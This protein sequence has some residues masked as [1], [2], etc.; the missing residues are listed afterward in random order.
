[1]IGNQMFITVFTRAVTGSC[2]DPVA[3]FHCAVLDEQTVVRARKAQGRAR[4]LMLA[5]RK[6]GDSSSVLHPTE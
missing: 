4:F 2:S 3:G 6:V 1:M 5:S